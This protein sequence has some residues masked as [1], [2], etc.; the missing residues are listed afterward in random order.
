[1]I[2]P[3]G[4]IFSKATVACLVP[5]LK[6][7]IRIPTSSTLC[8]ILLHGFSLS[9]CS[10]FLQVYVKIREVLAWELPP[11]TLEICK[12]ISGK[13]VESVD[14]F[15]AMVKDAVLRE[16]SGELQVGYSVHWGL[17]KSIALGVEI[18]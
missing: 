15:Y 13:E 4:S 17:T 3:S 2:A 1:M 5:C 7:S 11:L 14:G 18:S 6:C 10:C 16:A 9:T 12:E 8:R